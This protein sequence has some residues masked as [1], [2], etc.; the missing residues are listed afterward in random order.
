MAEGRAVCIVPT[1]MASFYGRR[2]LHGQQTRKSRNIAAGPRCVVSVATH[3]I[4]LF[5]E[6]SASRVTH[7]AGLQSVAAAFVEQGWPA[8]VEGDALTAAYC[9]PS[10]GPPPWHA[11][12]IT[13]ATVLAFG[14]A[15]P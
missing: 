1:S 3:P 15:G 7:T 13:P 14:T 6:G 5:I 12:R 8:R 11:Y 4:D 9:A 10:A 2:D